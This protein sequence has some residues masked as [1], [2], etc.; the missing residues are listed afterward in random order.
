MRHASGGEHSEPE[1]VMSR[2]PS[3]SRRVFGLVQQ[4]Q[5]LRQT[6]D[7]YVVGA[8]RR[9]LVQGCDRRVDVCLTG[10]FRDV[11]GRVRV[12]N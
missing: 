10:G 8:E 4:H 6:C 9:K 12:E 3:V 7:L 2:A 1:P 5:R 11:I